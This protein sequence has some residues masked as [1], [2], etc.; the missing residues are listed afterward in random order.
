[1]EFILTEN[2]SVG[3]RA[4]EAAHRVEALELTQ[5][6][7][8]AF[9]NVLALGLLVVQ[10]EPGIAGAPVGA[11]RV[12]ALS[13]SAQVWRDLALINVCKCFYYIMNQGKIK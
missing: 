1:M 8:I 5:F 6:G 11:H 13:V 7:S 9:V 2:V 3:T 4:D 12:D 10:S